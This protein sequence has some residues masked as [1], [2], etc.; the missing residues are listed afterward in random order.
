MTTYIDVTQEAGKEFFMKQVE[1]EIVMLNLLKFKKIANYSGLENLSPK[2][3]I[4]GKEAY[5][6]YIN[7]TLP[8]LKEAGSEVLF[9]GSG[10]SF[11]IG[12][13]KEKWDAVLLMKHVSVSKFM[14]FAQNKGYLSG[15]GHRKAALKDSRLLPIK[16]KS[17][18]E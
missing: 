18:V 12:P 6:I 17:I 11:L 3:E 10:S 15:A 2:T 14:D 8:F 4:S 16:E 5:Q 13:E 7:H 9:Y 1:G